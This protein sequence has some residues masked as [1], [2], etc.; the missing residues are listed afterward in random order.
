MPLKDKILITLGENT[1]ILPEAV[2]SGLVA[3]DKIKYFL[4]L[5]Q[6][7]KIKAATNQPFKTNL[8]IERENAGINNVIYDNVIEESFEI[9]EN[10]FY[11][12][13]LVNIL[14]EIFVCIE[15]MIKPLYFIKKEEKY[16]SYNNRLKKLIDSI[17]VV[18]KNTISINSIE[19]LTSGQREKG[20]SIHLLVMDLHQELNNLLASLSLESI[21][22]AKVFGLHSEDSHIIKSFMAGINKTAHLKFDHPG[23]GTTATRLGQRLIIQNDIGITD[24]H[25]LVIYVDDLTVTM[26]YTDIHLNRVIFF[27][28]LLDKYNV[29]WSSTATKEDKEIEGSIYHLITGKYSTCDIKELDNFLTDLGSKIVFMIDWNR[30]RKKL[31]RFVS[32]KKA[33][34]ILKW[35][36]QNDVGHMAFLNLGGEKIV[37][38]IINTTG[39]GTRIL[40]GKLDEFLGEEKASE[41]I[42]TVLKICSN[43]LINN[44]TKSLIFDEI[45]AEL[46]NYLKST[47]DTI[48]DYISEL[49]SYIL[50]I[51]SMIRDSFLTISSEKFLST[52][53][54]NA[55]IAKTLERNADEIV[56][57]VRNL[58]DR[59]KSNTFFKKLVSQID[60]VID[61]LEDATFHLTLQQ[62]EY[63][64]VNVY[65]Y[66]QELAEKIVFAS[67]ECIKIIEII[68]DIKLKNRREDIS[69]F[70]EAI[71]FLRLI[72][73]ETD[74]IDRQIKKILMKESK[75]FK[76][77][78]PLFEVSE[79]LER[80]GDAFMYVSEMFYTFIMDS[81][82][83]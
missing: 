10:T 48:I 15:E 47:E 14:K 32:K 39:A 54:K 57:K 49:S 74:S 37:Y 11:I 36:S 51:A 34:E 45:K 3:N 41:F 31:Q 64:L 12:P 19:I 79:R 8:R 83:S 9:K 75:N 18:E 56:I 70:L 58:V 63:V 65:P 38:E 71:H 73:Q 46:S 35:S 22:G 23:L 13:G 77:Y 6:S 61:Y 4:T 2:N 81:Y 42:K 44:R 24:A 28:E 82:I 50:D 29:T 53:I 27:Q 55:E 5:L 17:E 16:E 72:E 40:E 59:N 25:V 60:D 62:E 52:I 69:D 67:M 43:G 20:D 7:A 76:E 66:L 80:A 21:D 26:T 33:I 30:A 1:I 68:K 78:L